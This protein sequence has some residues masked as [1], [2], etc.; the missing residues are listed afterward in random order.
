ME[1]EIQ[2]KQGC[3]KTPDSAAL[4]RNNSSITMLPSAPGRQKPLLWTPWLRGIMRKKQ[5][6]DVSLVPVDARCCR[7]SLL[8]PTT[9]LLVQLQH[10]TTASN[11]KLPLHDQGYRNK[12]HIFNFCALLEYLFLHLTFPQSS[13]WTNMIIIK[14]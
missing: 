14:L 12:T 4:N 5:L 3:V 10:T 2:T 11:N 8:M 9:Y 6:R 13:D 1:A 7:Y